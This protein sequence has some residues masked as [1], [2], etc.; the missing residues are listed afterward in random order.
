M[1]RKIFRTILLSHPCRDRG[2]CGCFGAFRLFGRRE[3][4]FEKIER[5]IN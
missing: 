2:D 1:I 3:W 4:E 5:V